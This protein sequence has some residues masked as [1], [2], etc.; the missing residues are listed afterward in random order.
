M[1]RRNHFLN[2]AASLDEA[3]FIALSNKGTYKRAVKD[4]AAAP[5]VSMEL[6]DEAARVQ[7][8]DGTAVTF[9]GD[10]H[11]FS[12]SC[13]ARTVCKHVI[14]ALLAAQEEAGEQEAEQRDFSALLSIDLRSAAPKLWE[15]LCFREPF[16]AQ[17]VIEEG[18][19][20]LLSFPAEAITVRFLEPSLSAAVCTCKAADV[21]LHKAEALY[22]YQRSKGRQYGEE[23]QQARV[24][25]AAEAEPFR[26]V[27]GQ[28]LGGGLTRMPASIIHELEGLSVQAR[29]LRLPRLENMLRRLAAEIDLY[30]R[31]HAGFQSASYRRLAADFYEYLLLLEK[32]RICDM[33]RAD[34]YE[35][36]PLLLHGMGAAGWTTKSG[37]TGVTYYLYEG[38]R[39]RLFTYTQSRPLFYEG[40]S[41]TAKQLYE[42]PAPWGVSGSGSLLSRSSVRL[43]RAKLS[44]DG[45]LSSSTQTIGEVI[46]ATDLSACSPPFLSSWEEL[47]L[48]VKT[49]EGS[50]YLIEAAEA[51]R[52]SYHELLQSWRVP[53]MDAAGKAL[54]LQVKPHSERQL[55]QLKDYM[56]LP[57]RKRLLVYP[58]VEAGR[59]MVRP[60]V[61]YTEA[62]GIFNVT[63]EE[64]GLL[65]DRNRPRY[66]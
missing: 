40:R 54:Q 59:L 10:I 35:V 11:R 41:V 13:G 7:L 9:T 55:R 39:Q 30:R 49:E 37:Y 28:L 17:P 45:Q 66:E 42:Q 5:Q 4:L 46:G 65:H 26:T 25:S 63:L 19:S 20:L 33:P 36:P 38:Q 34:Y 58:H 22:A 3:Y 8:A 64:G 60:A 21:C 1:D 62:G 48:R 18:A 16:Q 53:L 15:E 29:A 56:E 24:L 12:C 61:C 14:M 27:A 51:G 57:G 2:T 23:G 47:L 6:T 32:G 50:V 44:R 52:W 43:H 31:K